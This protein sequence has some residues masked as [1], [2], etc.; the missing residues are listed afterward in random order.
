[1]EEEEE[2]VLFTANLGFF[3]NY[4]DG[5]TN[6]EIESELYKLAFQSKGSV[7]Y[8]RVMG[9]EFDSLEQENSNDAEVLLMRFA[10]NMIESVYR[11]NEEK[12][13]SP[14]IVMG[15]DDIDIIS[16]GESPHI[17]MKYRLLDNLQIN[18]EIGIG[19]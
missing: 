1:M 6:D 19:A 7:H 18:G 17:M 2:V 8:D 13:F 9:G 16:K 11:L 4:K 15:F 5:T 12:G 14:Y 10:A 3:L